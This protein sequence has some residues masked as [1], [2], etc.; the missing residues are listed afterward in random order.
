MSHRQYNLSCLR[1][2]VLSRCIVT[3]WA[4]ITL[5]LPAWANEPLWTRDERLE[6]RQ[7]VITGTV[8]KVEDM[9]E[10]DK[11]SRLF[12]ADITIT[13]TAKK[14]PELKDTSIRV[15]YA[16]SNNGS[17][18]CPDFAALTK[19]MT[20]EFFLVRSDSLTKKQDFIIPMGSDVIPTNPKNPPTKQTEASR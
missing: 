14:H 2:S 12:A 9:G 16:G 5:G 8:I 13:A 11:H 17:S 20:A 10:L 3:I 15:Y 7:A 1:S 19:G 6:L 4:S 18:R